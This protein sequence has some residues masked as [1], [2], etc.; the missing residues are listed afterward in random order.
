M[1][2]SSLADFM[3]DWETLLKNVTDTATELPDMNVYKTA[4]EQLAERARDGIAL[5]HS[6]RGFKQQETLE[7][8]SVMVE[9]KDAAAKLRSAIKAHFGPR[10]ERLIQYGMTPIRKRSRK[11]DSKNK[12]PK[13]GEPAPA[14]PSETT[15]Q[16]S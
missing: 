7:R 1:P 14:S 11:A 4:L 8:R 6:R 16:E 5:A 10:S 3:S 15:P 2:K 12:K 9:G 13:P